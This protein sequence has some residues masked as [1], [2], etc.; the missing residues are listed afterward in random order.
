M[1]EREESQK[2]LEPWTFG[3]FFRARF[4]AFLLVGFSLL[5]SISIAIRI[6]ASQGH[7][8]ETRT[9][10]LKGELQSLKVDGRTFE[11]TVTGYARTFS[12]TGLTAGDA[13]LLVHS[14]KH[15]ARMT[16]TVEER[17]MNGSGVVPVRSL[18]GPTN[19]YLKPGDEMLRFQRARGLAYFLLLVLAIIIVGV[20]WSLKQGFAKVS[21]GA[22]APTLDFLLTATLKQ[23]N[24]YIGVYLG[25]VFLMMA[26]HLDPSQWLFAIAFIF[27][28]FLAQTIWLKKALTV[29]PWAQTFLASETEREQKLLHRPEVSKKKYLKAVELIIRSGKPVDIRDD[30]GRTPLHIAAA[31]GHLEAVSLLLR[32]GADPNGTDDAGNTPVLLAIKA[33][34][35]GTMDRLIQANGTI[36]RGND[37]GESAMALA[38]KNQ[39]SKPLLELITRLMTVQ[40][41]LYKAAQEGKI[42]GIQHALSSGAKIDMPAESGKNALLMAIQGK[43]SAIARRL[44]QLGAK[45]TSPMVK[46]AQEAGDPALAEE[47]QKILYPAGPKDQG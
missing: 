25:I 20:G 41:Q 23:P 21:R 34:S 36:F 1:S 17:L 38:E 3:D 4:S 42:D 6:S 7:I 16:F 32:H 43:H 29:A 31:A 35:L 37:A 22:P 2:K 12:V 27:V 14:E 46:A 13:A 47:F 24:A 30:K 15:G 26:P 8:S 10:T 44:V 18:S 28:L 5:A 19:V 40:N 11:F 45:I 9:T 39:K 33:G